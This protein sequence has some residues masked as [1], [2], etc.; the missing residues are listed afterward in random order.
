MTKRNAHSDVESRI[1][2]LFNK[3]SSMS[4]MDWFDYLDAEGFMDDGFLNWPPARDAAERL[5][6]AQADLNMLPRKLKESDVKMSDPL[7]VGVFADFIA[8]FGSLSI[9]ERQYSTMA[10]LYNIGKLIKEVNG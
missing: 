5:R 4:Q 8:A 1:Q 7:T 10:I 2:I 9:A 6:K 3:E